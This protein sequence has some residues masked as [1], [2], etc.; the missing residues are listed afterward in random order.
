MCGLGEQSQ[1]PH[2]VGSVRF[3]DFGHQSRQSGV[4]R[5]QHPVRSPVPSGGQD[6]LGAAPVR[7]VGPT[8]DPPFGVETFEQP[9]DGGAGE[10]QAVGELARRRRA[11]EQ[12]GHRLCLGDRHRDATR[13]F[14]GAVQAE[15]ADEPEQRVAQ[16]RH[17]L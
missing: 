8:T 2:D 4:A 3:V 14:V 11:L 7:G 16:L 6:H 1:R 9:T 12:Q 17:I 10:G 5:R 15:G 13:G